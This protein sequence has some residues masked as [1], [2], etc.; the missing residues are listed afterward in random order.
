MGL[1]EIISELS[2]IAVLMDREFRIVAASPGHRK[3]LRYDLPDIAGKTFPMWTEA[4]FQTMAPIGGP[5]GWWSNGI[6][7]IDFMIMRKPLERAGNLDP[8]Y[9]KVTTMT[10]QDGLGEKY[11]FALTRTIPAAEFITAPPQV[12]L[13]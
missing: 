10:T 4:M 1:P 8:I 11:R 9:Q 6:K 3:M 7:R 5:M 13:F 2:D 12:T